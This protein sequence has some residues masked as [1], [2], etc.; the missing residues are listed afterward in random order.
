VGARVK[1][2][3]VKKRWQK[4]GTDDKK[5]VGKVAQ[6]GKSERGSDRERDSVMAR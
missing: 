2:M 5:R 1:I 3:E 6:Q 4:K